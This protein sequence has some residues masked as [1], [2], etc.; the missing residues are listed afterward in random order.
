M[1]VKN[2]ISNRSGKTVRNQFVIIDSEN[3]TIFFQSYDSVVAKVAPDGLTLGK[4]WD[5]SNTTLK[6]L[7][8]FLREYAYK[9]YSLI[10]ENYKKVCKATIARAITENLIEYDY[11]L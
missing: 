8:A 9:Y 5:Y 7:Y 11:N 3:N 1:K 2:L 4:D 10:K 6:Y